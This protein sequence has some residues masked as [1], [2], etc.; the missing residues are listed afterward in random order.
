MTRR[1]RLITQAGLIARLAE[2][3]SVPQACA[4][5]GIS[6]ATWFRWRREQALRVA[7]W[8]AQAAGALCA[9]WRQYHGPLL[10]WRA[11]RE[12]FHLALE[13]GDTS[14]LPASSAALVMALR[15][16]CGVV[17]PGFEVVTRRGLDGVTRRHIWRKP[18][19]PITAP[20]LC[21]AQTRKGTPCQC[22]AEVGKSRCKRH[23]GKSTGPKTEAGRDAI[24]ESNRNRA[25]F[26]RGN[27]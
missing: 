9:C 13:T 11:A 22:W 1:A 10:E 25:K 4:A 23:G 18:K 12:A 7:L 16:T 19:A 24:R 15:R 26:P 8:E 3:L 21:G 20:R 27:R 6:R 2:G 5:V 17:P 14:C